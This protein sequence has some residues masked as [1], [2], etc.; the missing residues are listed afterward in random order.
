MNTK[1]YNK[2]YNKKYKIQNK[3]YD[4]IISCSNLSRHVKNNYFLINVLLDSRLNKYSKCVIGKNSDKFKNI[5]NA[6]CYNLLPNHENI[7][8]LCQ[9]KLLLFPSLFDAN[10]NTVREAYIGNCL[11]LTTKN[12]GFA[13]RFPN[14]LLC[15]SFTIKEWVNKIINIMDNYK[16]YNNTKINYK[17]KTIDTF[18]KN[19]NIKKSIPI[20]KNTS[21]TGPRLAPCNSLPFVNL[22][23]HDN[24][25]CK[26]KVGIYATQLPYNGGASTLAY[27]LHN[28]L[29][30]YNIDSKLCFYL[31]EIEIDK[32]V[33]NNKLLNPKNYN[34]VYMLPRLTKKLE[35]SKDTLIKL[36]DVNLVIAINYEIVPIIR[37]YYKGKII[38]LIV[39]SPEF[40]LGKN[41][42]I[43]KNVSY[44]NFLSNKKY[45]IDSLKKSN[46]KKRNKFSL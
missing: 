41:S 5:P 32:V 8:K 18:I 9:S 19:I 21:R 38:Y 28:Y 30:K 33:N 23:S 42:P 10:P 35:F 4:I 24:M 22:N 7:K 20:C 40:T 29:I 46:S 6:V 16:I 11:T 25:C 34:Q 44:N 36:K 3:I 39:G 13:D 15:N 43:S 45:N 14:Y 26:I 17:S 1:K 37:D 27:N 31:K 2:K 12:I